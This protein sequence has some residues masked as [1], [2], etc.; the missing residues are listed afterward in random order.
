MIEDED[1]EDVLKKGIT[2]KS[3][4]KNLFV[5]FLIILGAIFIYFGIFPDQMTNFMIGFMLI[6]FGS[7]II[8][9]PKQ[10]SEPIRQT[11][12]ILAC[13][14]CSITK[15]RNFETGDFVFKVKDQCNKCNGSMEIKQ[16]YNVRLKKPTEPNKKQEEKTKKLEINK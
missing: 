1:D 3:A 11:L 7:T 5:I 8:Q 16:I 15:V 6:C 4:L 13:N 9:I 2:L 12:T 10:E 14:L